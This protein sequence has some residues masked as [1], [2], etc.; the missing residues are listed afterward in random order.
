MTEY[1]AALSNPR[2]GEV[3]GW[4]V[5]DDINLSVADEATAACLCQERVPVVAVTTAASLLPETAGKEVV[6]QTAHGREP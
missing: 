6:R 5:L 1:T 4:V 2:Q 3:S